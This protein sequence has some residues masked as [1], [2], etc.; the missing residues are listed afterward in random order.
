M[1]ICVVYEFARSVSRLHKDY[2]CVFNNAEYRRLQ[3][4]VYK[5]SGS[6]RSAERRAVRLYDIPVYPRLKPYTKA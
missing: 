4:K 6:R 5:H 3:A 2:V 1:V